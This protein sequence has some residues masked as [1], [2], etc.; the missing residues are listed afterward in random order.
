MEE[1]NLGEITMKIRTGLRVGCTDWKWNDYEGA[2]YRVCDAEDNGHKYI[3][4][5]LC[6]RNPGI[7]NAC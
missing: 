1:K 3:R 5:E 4:I 7:G 6:N 2:F